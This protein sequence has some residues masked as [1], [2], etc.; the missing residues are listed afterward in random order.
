MRDLNTQI[1]T[2]EGVGSFVCRRRTMRVAIAITA[3]Y[4]RLTEGAE[5][6]SHEFA[7]ICNF[8]AYLRTIVVSGPDDWSPYDV[9]PDDGEAMD[10]L[11]QVYQ[12]IKDS[13]A[14]FRAKPGQEPQE[15]GEGSSGVD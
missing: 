15:S 2:V 14:R 13:E 3:E 9:D 10:R 11:R 6:V 4:N 5:N 7:G 12:A 1:V 8:M